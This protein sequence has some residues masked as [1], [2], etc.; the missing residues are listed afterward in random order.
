MQIAISIVDLNQST[1]KVHGDT[2]KN[3][4]IPI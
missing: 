2:W 3:P 1:K 4:S